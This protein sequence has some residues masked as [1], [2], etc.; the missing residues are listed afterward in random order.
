[1][2]LPAVATLADKDVSVYYYSPAPHYASLCRPPLGSLV[3]RSDLFASLLAL[4]ANW[5]GEGAPAIAVDD[6]ELARQT[7]RHFNLV[8]SMMNGSIPR[9]HVM[10]AGDGSVAISWRSSRSDSDVEIWF[11]SRKATAV[12]RRGDTANE[13]QGFV[14]VLRWL[15]DEGL[16]VA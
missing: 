1:M 10:A 12:I 4:G 2:S 7:L 15:K 9:P 8:A 14:H 16:L 13:Y 6:V 3:A 11:G 5:D